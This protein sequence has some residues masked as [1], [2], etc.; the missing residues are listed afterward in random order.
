VNPEDYA[1]AY[2]VLSIGIPIL[3]T[4][5]AGLVCWILRKR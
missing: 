5:A 4:F 2:M 3:I 1:N